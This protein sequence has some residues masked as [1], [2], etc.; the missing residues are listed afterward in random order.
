MKESDKE[1][2]TQNR[3][4]FIVYLRFYLLHAMMPQLNFIASCTKILEE[5]KTTNT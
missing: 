4:D 3:I 2:I 5:Y 1:I